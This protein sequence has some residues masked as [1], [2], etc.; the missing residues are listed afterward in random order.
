[1]AVQKIAYT[2]IVMSLFRC[3][4]FLKYTYNSSRFHFNEPIHSAQHRSTVL[5]IGIGLG[6][7]ANRG[8]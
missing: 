1:M 8:E 3:L 4:L 2:R 7:Y 5:C 6:L